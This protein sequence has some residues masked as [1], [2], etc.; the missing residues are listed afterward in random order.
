[1]PVRHTTLIRPACI[2]F[3]LAAIVVSIALPLPQ[4]ARAQSD[5]RFQPL[6]NR[7]VG[8]FNV[9]MSWV[10]PSPQV[11]IINIGVKPAMLSDGSP[12]TDA[13]ITLVAESEPDHP[14]FE[15]VAVNTPNDPEVYRANL[16]FEEAGNWVVQVK[17]DSPTVGQADFR[18]PLVILPAPIEPGVGGAWVFLGI[19]L[20]LTAGS[21]Y[22]I[23]AI[24]KSQAARRMRLEGRL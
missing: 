4:V 15:V 22:I 20:V 24:R 9:G 23:M 3:A 16:K 7:E 12:V 21:V 13:R 5:E 10:P 19:F 18:S 14:E 1:M 8:P 6:F 11:G 17:I 2:A